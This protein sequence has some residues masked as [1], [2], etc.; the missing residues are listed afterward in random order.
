MIHALLFDLDGVLCDLMALHEEAFLAAVRVEGHFDLGAIEHRA[1]YAGRSTKQKLQMLVDI[2]LITQQQV[3][4]IAQAKQR[5]T[6]TY[7]EQQVHPLTDRIALLRHFQTAGYGL[8]CVTNCIKSTA[9]DVLNRAGLL[10]FVER[11]VITNED[12][13]P[14]PSP[15]P[16]QKACGLLETAPNEAL[17]FEDHEVGLAAAKAAGCLTQHVPT[18]GWLSIESVWEAIE[19]AEMVQKM[20]TSS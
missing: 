11:C 17:V 12:A 9:F 15:E 10:P 2:G 18:Y 14:K 16:Y 7:V 6:Q 19:G 5:L 13:Q 3:S 20:H 4:P 1:H 8:G